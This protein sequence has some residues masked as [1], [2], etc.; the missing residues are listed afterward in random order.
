MGT[1][2]K[3][4]AIPVEAPK[5]WLVPMRD[6]WEAV[7]GRGTFPWGAAGKFLKPLRQGYDDE[8]IAQRLKVYLGR[9]PAQFLNL[10]RF[11]QTIEQ[12]DPKQLDLPLVDEFGMLREQ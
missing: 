2:A 8:E 7:N 9:T 4:P 6:V 3:R 10:S 12:Y 5:R 11:A 1:K